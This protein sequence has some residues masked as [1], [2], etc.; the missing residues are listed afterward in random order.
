MTTYY[1][2]KTGN[3]TT[4]D[5]S[6]GNPW[7]TLAKALTTVSIAGG[8]TILIGAGTYAEDMGF[9]HCV[10][11][12]RNFTAQV[13]VKSET[14]VRSDVIIT[15][16]AA[17]G[18]TIYYENAGHNVF[19]EAVTIQQAGAT[20]QGT[21]RF[22]STSSGGFTGCTIYCLN[23]TWC[24]YSAGTGTTTIT[25]TNCTLEKYPGQTGNI[26]P[27][28]VNVGAGG[29]CNITLTNCTVTGQNVKA[30][31]LSVTDATGTFNAT[32]SGGT[33]TGSGAFVTGA[34]AIHARGGHCDITGITAT[35]NETPAV[36]FGDDGATTLV[37]TGSISDSTIVSGTS[38]SLLIG[39]NATVAV[40]NCIVAGGDYAVVVKMNDGTTIDHCTLDG[41]SI[42]TVYFK[43]ALN[44]E[45]LHSRISNS[46]G[47]L[48]LVGVGDA[49][50]KSQGIV[51]EHN[52]LFGN[53][54]SA[55]FTWSGSSGDDGGSVCDYNVYRHLGSAFF[56]TVY[57]TASVKTL[58]GARAAWA[59]YG[60]GSNDSHSRMEVGDD[61]IQRGLAD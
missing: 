29:V 10:Y 37:T 34:Y 28:Y 38:H 59:G 45:V 51:V 12:N 47:S 16:A 61:L 18:Y 40:D 49:G 3:D 2:R 55:L 48:I 50:Q 58:A 33:Y 56:G 41:G 31:Y 6:T 43:G 27:V 53:G 23:S 1:V 32:I 35:R 24:V 60:D 21:V 20:G 39:Y 9:P 4:G 54:A 30:C 8:H 44:G 22:L 46:A 15:A 5:G 26:Q 11:L 7:L 17:G 52:L 25:L 42:A 36:A 57:G 14:G 19:W 13:L